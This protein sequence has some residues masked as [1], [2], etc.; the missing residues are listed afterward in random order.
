M[1][2]GVYA[3]FVLN[4]QRPRRYVAGTEE[5]STAIQEYM[6]Q[7]GIEG[8]PTPEQAAHIMSLAMQGDTGEQPETDVTPAVEQKQDD[9]QPDAAKAEEQEKQEDPVL[10]AKDGKHTIPYEELTNART[11]A[12]E[13]QRLAAEA[14][15]RADA[16]AANNAA[17]EQQIAAQQKPAEPQPLPADEYKAQLR[18]LRIAETE[19]MMDGDAQ[20]VVE[21]RE[22]M[23][24]LT[25]RRY[26]AKQPEAKPT[27][28]P[29]Q[30]PAI[31]GHFAAIRAAHPDFESVAESKELKDWMTGQISAV[32]EIARPAV[33]AEFDRILQRGTA[34]DVIGLLTQ[35]KAGAAQKASSAEAAAAAAVAGAKSRAPAS[36]SEIPGAA[37]AASP[38]AALESLSPVDLADRMASMTPEQI[39]AYLNRK[40]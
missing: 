26:A 2:A 9:A 14:Q 6:E 13:A 15:A 11:A 35:Y 16:L 38:F 36:L 21:L 5:M 32:P 20:K 22:Q 33:Q 27:E 1:R 39:T 3:G 19:A 28:A 40:G 24:E 29:Q 17:L 25:E 31:A 7:Q 30:D 23:D 37:P 34:A 12:Q 10:L 18:A 8:N 4:P